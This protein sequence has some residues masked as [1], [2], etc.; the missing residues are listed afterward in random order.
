MCLESSKLLFC[1]S[2]SNGRA[3]HIQNGGKG[4][5]MKRAV[6][7]RKGEEKVERGERR[8]STQNHNMTLKKQKL[9]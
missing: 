7:V 5:T 9:I 2:R 6:L 1:I 3:A 4:Q 8:I